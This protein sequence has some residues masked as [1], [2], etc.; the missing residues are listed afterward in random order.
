MLD[1][2]DSFLLGNLSFFRV[3]E[4]V[5]HLFQVFDA[6]VD[7]VEGRQLVQIAVIF[8]S[9]HFFQHVLL[10]RSRVVTVKT[11]QDNIMAYVRL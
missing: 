6:F 10:P 3:V 7:F 1:E 8:D 11:K 9:D 2:K 4:T 5:C